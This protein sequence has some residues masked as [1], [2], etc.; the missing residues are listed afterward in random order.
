MTTAATATAGH[1]LASPIDPDRFAPPSLAQ[2][3][4]EL[5]AIREPARLALGARRL[6]ATPCGTSRPVLTL[7]GLGATDASMAP[8][9]RYL[10]SRDH[11]AQGWGL[12]RNDG[13]VESLIERATPVAVDLAERAG[14][15]INL[16][17]W[18]LGGVLAR[19][20]AR[21]RPDIVHRVATFGTPL[22][23][24]RHT[25]AVLAYSD[26]QLDQVDALIRQ[27]EQRPI[28][29]PVLAIYSRNDG[30]VDWRTCI[31]R[32]SPHVIHRRAKGTHLA[33]GLDPDV[34]RWTA[35]WFADRAAGHRPVVD[36]DTAN[37]LPARP[38]P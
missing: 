28:T 23:G 31:D 16:L 12:G 9:R 30:I 15:P 7:P 38:S 18:S 22:T 1:D 26:E 27:R 33:M 24:P 19:E 6:A 3:A 11:D 14:R 8:I 10:A 34:W 17:G 35:E 36:H 32:T 29:R 37:T 2:R 4:R 20:I 25:A 5:L 13:D 21:D